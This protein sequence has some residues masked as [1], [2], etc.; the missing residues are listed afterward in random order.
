M[1]GT[2]LEALHD[3]FLI[4]T[5]TLSGIYYFTHFTDEDPKIKRDER[6]YL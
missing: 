6:T 5:I 3:I 4:L 1:S 2:E